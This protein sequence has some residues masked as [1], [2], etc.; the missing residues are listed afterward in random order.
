MRTIRSEAGRDRDEMIR[1]EMRRD[2]DGV[3]EG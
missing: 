3:Y 2:V 1:D